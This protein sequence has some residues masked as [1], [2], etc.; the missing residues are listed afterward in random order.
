MLIFNATPKYETVKLRPE[1]EILLCC[2]RTDVNSEIRDK[3]LFLIQNEINW[4][5]LL[6]LAFRHRLTPFLYHNLN[7]ICSEMIPGDIL[8]ELNERFN[9]NVRKNLMIAGELIKV[10]NSL[11]S[12]GITAVPYN[13]PVLASM[14]YG[15]LDYGN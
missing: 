13:E 4:D 14:A 1:D 15:I 10:L 11:A 6:K 12:E 5:Y 7:Y 8:N 3:I 9:A 2:A